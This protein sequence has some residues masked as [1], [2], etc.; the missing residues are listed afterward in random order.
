MQGGNAPARRSYD[1]VTPY[2]W[3]CAPTPRGA[4]DIRRWH[5]AG[6]RSAA[7]DRTTILPLLDFHLG[8]LPAEILALPGDSDSQ[9]DAV[10]VISV[11]LPPCPI[12][13]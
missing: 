11:D 9:D 3:T 8:R 12:A 10:T 2:D 13:A 5:R 6:R 4:E 7:I 1:A